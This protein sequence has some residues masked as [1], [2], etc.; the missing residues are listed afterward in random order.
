MAM[1]VLMPQ[2][3]VKALLGVIDVLLQGFLGKSQIFGVN[4]GMPSLCAA[5][6]TCGV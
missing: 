5:G 6:L 1:R 2:Y 4:Q 3:L